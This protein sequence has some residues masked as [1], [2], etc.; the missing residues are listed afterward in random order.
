[1][2]FPE[3][4]DLEERSFLFLLQPPGGDANNLLRVPLRSLLTGLTAHHIILQ[5]IGTLLLKGTDHV[6]PR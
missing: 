2:A 5:M 4:P 6:I 1:M 3:N